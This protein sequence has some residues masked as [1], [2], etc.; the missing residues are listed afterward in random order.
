HAPPDRVEQIVAQADGNAFY[1]EELIRAVA[2]RAEDTLPATML[3]VAQARLDRVSP[4]ARRVLRAASVLGRRFWAGSIRA[5][6]GGGGEAV[7]ASRWMR[8]AA[9]DALVAHAFAEAL[10]RAERGLAMHGAQEGDELGRLALVAAQ[11]ERWLG[12]F[13]RAE[14]RAREAMLGLERGSAG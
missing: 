6:R 1:L 3:A 7:R 10:A 13:Q 9:E 11:A 14:S 5:L 2:E 12:S 4:E 8:R